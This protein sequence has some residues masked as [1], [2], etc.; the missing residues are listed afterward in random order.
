M[1]REMVKILKIGSVLSPTN[2]FSENYLKIGTI[3]IVSDGGSIFDYYI[4]KLKI[5]L[6]DVFKYQKASQSIV[7]SPEIR[8]RLSN[9]Y[10][11][12]GM[13]SSDPVLGKSYNVGTWYTSEVIKIIDEDII[14]TKNSVY[15]IHNTS[16]IRDKNLEDLGI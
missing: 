14:I 11:L 2:K 3:M 8:R 9:S 12:S 5:D 7:G 6:G 4:K 15:A 13:Q 1:G 10:E 16:K